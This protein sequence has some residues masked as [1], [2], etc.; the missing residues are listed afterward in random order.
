[1][2]Y[3]TP[4]ILPAGDRYVLIE[5]GNETNLEL[6][7]KA[8]GLAALIAENRPPGVIETAPAFAS[9]LVHY[10]PEEVDYARLVDALVE[11][12]GALGSS[13]ELELDSRLFYLPTAYLD[14]WSAEAI[15]RYIR[16]IAEKTR[17]PELI[18]E[19]NDLADTDQLVRV[20]SGSEYW[21]S[22]IGWWPGVPFMMALDPRCRL[23]VPKYDPPRIW[24]K[25]GTVG[26]GGSN[27]GIYPEDLPGGIQ[28]FARTPVPIWDREQ[29]FDVFRD[30]IC[31]LKPG[32]RIK[33]VP[34]TLEEFEAVERQVDEGSYVFN[35]V[36]YQKFSVPAYKAWVDGLDLSV[37]F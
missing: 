33:F 19:L 35:V 13:D 14:P 21:V 22:A 3:D 17:D 1:M 26:L 31:L 32:D 4:K 16:D 9:L 20:H 10:E 5:F 24:T 23:T 18:V 2:I 28:V 34:C 30:S 29:R 8:Q 37:R 7:F 27:V 25:K 15:D 6:N 12:T 36:E 11:L